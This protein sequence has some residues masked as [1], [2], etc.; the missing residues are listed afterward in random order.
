M[1]SERWRS[2]S[3]REHRGVST[4]ADVSLAL[5][6]LV[7]AM[8]VL[9]TFAETDQREHRPTDTD[10]TAQAVTGSTM[11]TSYTVTAAMEEYY[12]S[13][14]PADNPYEADDLRRVSHGP[15]A[16]QVAAIAVANLTVDGERASRETVEYRRTLDEHLQTRLLGSRFETSVS[17]IWQPFDGANVRG[18][19]ELGQQPPPDAD[20]STTTITVS[21]DVPKA[22][23]RAVDAVTAAEDGQA[24]S[25]LAETVANATVAGY[26]PELETQRALERTGVDTHLTRYRYERLAIALGANASV[27]DDEGWLA[28][29]SANVTAANAYLAERLAIV[30]ESRLDELDGTRFESAADAARTVST[31]TVTITIR[32]WTHD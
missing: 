9:V 25:A 24:Y 16:A 4:V 3:S 19:V 21:S 10:Y 30:F 1:G 12:Q 14:H 6:L 2:R 26:F 8:G 23:A 20:V 32:T 31:G 15:I 22:R 18:G 29:S 13:H 17:A 7:A 28:P 27:F 5:L 11:N